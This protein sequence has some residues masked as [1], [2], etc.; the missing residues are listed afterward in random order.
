MVQCGRGF[1]GHQDDE[2]V[3]V[4]EGVVHRLPKLL[5]LVLKDL[6]IL[7]GKTCNFLMLL[8][9]DSGVS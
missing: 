7:Q 3:L 5:T 4:V 8:L 6:T 9:L 2:E 1:L